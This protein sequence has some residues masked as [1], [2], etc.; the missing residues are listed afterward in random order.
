MKRILLMVTLAACGAKSSEPTAGSAQGSAVPAAKSDL[1]TKSVRLLEPEDVVGS[2][3]A[4]AT[5]MAT[6]LKNLEDTI[7]RYDVEHPHLLP[8]AVDVVV[9]AR[10][11]GTRLWLVSNGADF[12]TP[13][14]LDDAIAK[15]PPIPVSERH[16]AVILSM[17]RP[18]G[19]A[20]TTPKLPSAWTAVA[21]EKPMD[22][23]DVI[24]VVWPPR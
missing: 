15:L 11:T 23:D 1:A 4:S 6:G 22:I 5:N 13:P 9:V 24:D 7:G 8:A 17:A 21:K 18:S 10:T 19:T 3:V 20:A 16:V 12:A 2:R 14:G